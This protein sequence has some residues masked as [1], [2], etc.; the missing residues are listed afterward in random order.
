MNIAHYRP[1]IIKGE[2]GHRITG[3][4][5]GES[6]I[7][8]T[9]NVRINTSTYEKLI[10]E[11]ANSFRVIDGIVQ[12]VTSKPISKRADI[13]LTRTNKAKANITGE[14]IVG[15]HCYKMTPA[16]QANLSLNLA[17]CS[18]DSKHKCFL[19]TWV[20]DKKVPVPHDITMLV[21]LAKSF[22]ERRQSISGTLRTL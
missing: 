17:L 13:I 20:E 1:D 19:N 16:L 4:F 15:E 11:G 8:P 22:N 14:L 7:V 3:L 18:V 12:R 21:S 2:K 9:P 10:A 5:T 6:N